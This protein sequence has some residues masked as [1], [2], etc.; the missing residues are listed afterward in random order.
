VGHNRLVTEIS[1]YKSHSS[2][3]E[4]RTNL[5]VPVLNHGHQSLVL[6]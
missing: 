4:V 2:S 3:K 6:I 5:Q 1:K